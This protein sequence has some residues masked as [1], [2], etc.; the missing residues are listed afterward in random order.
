MLPLL[1]ARH[2]VLCEGGRKSAY[3][4]VLDAMVYHGDPI[5]GGALSLA[6]LGL[7]NL[8]P[9][10]STSDISDGLDMSHFMDVSMEVDDS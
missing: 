1:T 4:T 10:T 5:T 9:G 2:L 7:T 8:I 3:P 6:N